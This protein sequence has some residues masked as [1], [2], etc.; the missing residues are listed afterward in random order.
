MTKIA[1]K[2]NQ[3]F[4]VHAN[5]EMTSLLDVHNVRRLRRVKSQE[6][7]FKSAVGIVYNSSP[8]HGITLRRK[9]IVGLWIGLDK[10]IISG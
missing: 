3:R 1:K 10:K 7:I 5:I 6:L 9:S 2:N 4:Q 8:N